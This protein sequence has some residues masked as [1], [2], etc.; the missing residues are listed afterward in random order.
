MHQPLFI[1][2]QPPT[3]GKGELRCRAI[4]FLIGPQCQVFHIRTLTQVRTGVLPSAS[5][6]RAGIYQGYKKI[7]VI[8]PPI[9]LDGAVDSND[10]FITLKGDMNMTVKLAYRLRLITCKFLKWL[11]IA[12]T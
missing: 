6:H 4:T 10:R 5:Q 2:T 7:K 11:H 12:R 8:T 3:E 1:S 9:S